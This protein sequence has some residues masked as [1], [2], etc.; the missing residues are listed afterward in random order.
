MRIPARKIIN[1]PINEDVP[2]NPMLAIEKNRNIKHWTNYFTG[3]IIWVDANLEAQSK[4]T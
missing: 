3:I 2:G 4:V 1:S